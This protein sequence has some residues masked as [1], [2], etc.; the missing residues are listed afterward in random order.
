[1][2][3]SQ[4]AGCVAI[5]FILFLGFCYTAFFRGGSWEDPNINFISVMLFISFIWG[6]FGSLNS[7]AINMLS[8]KSGKSVEE[9]THDLLW[10][11]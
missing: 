11:E 6:I 7:W 2:K 5:T 10:R 4:T 3:I 9:V 8:K 1:M